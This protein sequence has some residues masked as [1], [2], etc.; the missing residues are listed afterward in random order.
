MA[1]IT[2]ARLCPFL[3]ARELEPRGSALPREWGRGP[4]PGN[5][6]V[7][8]PCVCSPQIA[9]SEF[10]FSAERASVARTCRSPFLHHRSRAGAVRAVADGSAVTP[11]VRVFGCTCVPSSRSGG[12]R[13]RGVAGSHRARAVGLVR[14]RLAGCRLRGGLRGG[15]AVCG[16]RPE[17]CGLRSVV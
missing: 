10:R 2:V 8:F 3:N 1:L 16:L 15:R 14:S 12:A 17:A 7:S 4:L 11:R 5:P 9:D 13:R 6:S